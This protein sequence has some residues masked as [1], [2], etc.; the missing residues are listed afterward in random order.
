MH[1]KK[2]QPG[3]S[4]KKSPFLVVKPLENNEL[5]VYSKLHG[6]LTSFNF[7]IN[8]VLKLFTWSQSNV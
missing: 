5:R 1:Q 7:N 4:L 3:A 6:N 2:W 8:E